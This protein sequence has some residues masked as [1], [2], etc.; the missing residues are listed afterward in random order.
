MSSK[1]R[2]KKYILIILIVI[3]TI[4]ILYLF[5]VFP[6]K[7]ISLPDNLQFQYSPFSINITDSEIQSEILYEL[8]PFAIEQEIENRGA[9]YGDILYIQYTGYINDICYESLK[10]QEIEF[11]LGTSGLLPDFESHFLGVYPYSEITFEIIFPEDY[12][13]INL[14]NQKV[15]FEVS[16]YKIVEI[17]YPELTNSFVKEHL[18]YENVQEYNNYIYQ[19]VY[20]L[21]YEM[22]SN[23]LQEELLLKVVESS[24]FDSQR[25]DPLIEIRFQNLKKAY[26]EYGQ[27]F[28]YNIDDVYKIFGTSEDILYDTATYEQKKSDVCK[29]IIKNQNLK[30][31]A[32][33]Y[34]SL[35]LDYIQQF[36][37]KTIND[38]IIDNGDDYL[39]EKIYEEIVKDY[40][41]NIAIPNG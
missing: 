3:L 33:K 8:R 40:L 24:V 12:I 22:E 35:C 17:I 30:P 41:F 37:Y 18:D 36:G 38:F 14:Q 26:T 28:G 2:G 9:Q 39:Q 27:L 15:K 34:Q 25:L 21:K 7:Y 11:E 4:A 10:N 16:V 1:N 23:S 6:K 32:E 29:L 19:K 20:D 13:D 5:Q 31:S